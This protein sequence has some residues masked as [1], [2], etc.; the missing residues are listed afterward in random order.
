ML[1]HPD[2]REMYQTQCVTD[3]S[4][5]RY[6]N[7]VIFNRSD[8]TWGAATTLTTTSDTL[9]SYAHPAISPDGVCLYFVS[10]ML[11]G[12]GGYD[13]WRVRLIGAIY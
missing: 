4:Y 1:F 9:L 11:G 10:A 12:Q 3:P 13:I 7:I 5:P 8:A 6:A 2:Q